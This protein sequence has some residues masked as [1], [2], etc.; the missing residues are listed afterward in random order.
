[1][2]LRVYIYK[3]R[4]QDCSNNGVSARYKQLTLTNVEG[5]FDPSDDAPAA[6]L[7]KRERVGNVVVKP[8]ELGSKWSMMGGC[9]VHSSDSR[10]G[11]AVR[12]LSGYAYGFP[13]AL[14]DR[15]EN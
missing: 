13:V 10:F 8:A 3:E 15:V 2:G 4:D 5:P 12:R 9:F 6:L 14:H 1:M 11:E 7:I